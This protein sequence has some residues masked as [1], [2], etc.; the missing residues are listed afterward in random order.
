HIFSISITVLLLRK[1][2]LLSTPLLF[3]ALSLTLSL[4][5]GVMSYELVEKRLRFGIKSKTL[6]QGA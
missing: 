4:L 3:V 2:N 5:A 1:T 6:N